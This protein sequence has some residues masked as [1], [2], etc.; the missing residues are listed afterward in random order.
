MSKTGFGLISK[1]KVSVPLIGT[2]VV[3]DITGRGCKVKVIQTFKNTEKN[4]I[5]AVYKFPLPESSAVCGFCI[6]TADKV[7]ISDIEERDSAFEKYD[8]AL[9]DKNGAYLLDEERPNIFTLSV[10]NLLPDATAVIEI[11]Y[12]TILDVFGSEVRFYLP[13]TISPR[14]V[15]NGL[16]TDGIPEDEI[17]NPE[18]ALDVPYGIKIIANINDK[19]N[20]M[21]IESPS[22]HISTDISSYPVKVSFTSDTVKMDRDFILNIKYE[23]GFENRGYVYESND[24]AFIQI[25]FTATLP[26]EYKETDTTSKEI[27][28]VLDCSGSMGGSSIQEAKRAIEIFIKA[29][30]EDVKFNIYRFGSKFKKL[31][32]T[33]VSYTE[34]NVKKAL[35]YISKID[36]DM[37]GT[38]VLSTLKDIYSQ[39]VET[40]H[41]R[42]I[43]LITDG[44]VGNETEVIDLV[45][46]GKDTHRLFTVGVGY[47]PNEYFIKQ[48][49]KISKGASEQIAPNERM[50]PKILRLYKKVFS[51][52]LKDFKIHLPDGFQQAPDDPAIYPDD[53][54]SIF[55]RGRANNKIPET[56]KITAELDKKPLQ[57]IVPI[58]KLTH[59]NQSMPQLWGQQR[60]RDLEEGS[61]LRGSKQVSRKQKKDRDEI[62]RVSKEFKVISR[63]TS[64]V[65]VEKR[66]EDEKTE[67]E[68][69]LRKVP[70]M[71]TKDWGGIK[72]FRFM[73]LGMTAPFAMSFM[74]AGLLNKEVVSI[75]CIPSKEY[76]S[77][78][79]VVINILDLQRYSGGFEVDDNIAKMLNTTVSKLQELSEEIITEEKTDKFK[80]LSTALVLCILE[81][82][83]NQERSLWKRLVQK[84]K[85]WL[86]TEIQRTKPTLQGVE[87]MK[88][89]KDYV[90]KNLR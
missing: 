77:D 16:H 29:I 37:G 4:P 59:D 20:I 13:T 55:A 15:P 60:I 85:K 66:T 9:I 80:I 34:Q 18:F 82:K 48:T 90:A 87:L 11:E 32:D 86:E 51:S 79:D 68:I 72:G 33:S 56:I 70:V 67:K 35:D 71:L 69:V 5:E 63:E 28:F 31:F 6:K 23:D 3:A 88:W 39:K 62:I 26:E 58:S 65:A 38:E 75:D 24:D 12:V 64:F 41:I 27:I 43:V 81:S 36:A 61:V 8:K 40:G 10:G 73:G 47:G 52:N 78:E 89:A 30:T 83:Y 19:D 74:G 49:A 46:S 84:S 76:R 54:I 14:Y 21:S 17:V 45:N 25:D 1:E 57:W 53:T 44:E 7:V 50:Q 22:H 2:E 42:N